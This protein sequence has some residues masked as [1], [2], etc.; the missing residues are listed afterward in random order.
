MY[1]LCSVMPIILTDKQVVQY[2]QM[3]KQHKLSREADRIKA[4]LMLNS[5]YSYEQIGELLLMDGES[6]RRWHKQYELGGMESLLADHYTGGKAKL[7]VKAQEGL[8]NYLQEHICLSAKE[9]CHYVSRRYGEEYTSKGMTNLLHRLGFT[10]KKPKHLPSKG[11]REAQ[12]E[13]INQ[14]EE[15]NKNKSPKDKIYF[16]DGTHPLHNSQ[17]GYGWIKKG[18]DKFVKAN[19]GR[20]RV[21]ING[22]YNVEEH[23]V[24]VRED[25]RI[26]AQSTVSLLKQMLQEQPAGV[27]HIILDNARYYRSKHVQE[28]ISENPRIQFMFLP[29]YSPNLNL[30]ERLWK[31]LKKKIAYNKYYEKF[32]VFRQKILEFFQNITDYREELENLMTQNFQLFPA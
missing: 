12:E 26:N 17:L 15:L 7:S 14:Y 29:P 23:K 4:I 9:V 18:E 25:E 16:M 22:A 24:V 6:I 28:F 2:K 3:H 19:T 21:N 1:D 27:I 5:G 13:F 30:I 32:S 20:D 11:D 31:L 8:S 10:Y